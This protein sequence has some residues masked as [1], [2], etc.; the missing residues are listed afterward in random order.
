MTIQLPVTHPAGADDLALIAVLT[1]RPAS[2][3]ALELQLTRQP[4]PHLLH[5]FEQAADLFA[6]IDAATSNGGRKV[7]VVIVDLRKFAS[8]LPALGAKRDQFGF[9]LAAF[10]TDAVEYA[11][12]EAAAAAGAVL[13]SGD[14]NE[15]EGVQSITESL[16]DVW[17]GE[18]QSLSRSAK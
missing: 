15:R 18:G 1:A 8:V 10:P 14:L 9:V 16:V 5:R 11:A 13:V 12:V 3:S 2:A 7:D 17:F 4:L 6:F